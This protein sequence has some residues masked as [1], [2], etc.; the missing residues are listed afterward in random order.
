MKGAYSSIP[1]DI[2]P[3]LGVRG[4]KME[5]A[6]SKRKIFFPQKKGVR[7]AKMKGAYSHRAR[8]GRYTVV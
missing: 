2:S 6:Y 3:I 7:G 1:D 8:C 5:G 4:A